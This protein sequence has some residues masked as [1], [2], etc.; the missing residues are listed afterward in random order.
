MLNLHCQL[1]QYMAVVYIVCVFLLA[2]E[3]ICG[4][5]LHKELKRQGVAQNQLH[6]V[7]FFIF[8]YFQ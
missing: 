2:Q 1:F 6:P 4:Q 7:L 3:Q 8:A 5:S